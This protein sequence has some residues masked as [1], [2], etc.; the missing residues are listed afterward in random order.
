MYSYSIYLPTYHAISTSNKQKKKTLIFP[1]TNDFQ[2]LWFLQ[3]WLFEIK[4][5]T[6]LFSYVF[7]VLLL[8]NNPT[9]SFIC[10]ILGIKI[11]FFAL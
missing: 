5:Q 8:S 1:D 6:C 7:K 9:F 10:I 11:R 2:I 3:K 4:I